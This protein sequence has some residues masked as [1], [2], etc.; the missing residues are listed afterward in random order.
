MTRYHVDSDA[1]LSATSQAQGSIGRIQAEIQSLSSQLHSLQASWSGTAASAFQQ[2]LSEW[3]VTQ[4]QVEGQL[5]SLT[6][7]LGQV[8]AHYAELEAQNTRLFMR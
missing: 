3:L 6:Q 2:V 5:I 8:G 7:T 4:Q 1:V